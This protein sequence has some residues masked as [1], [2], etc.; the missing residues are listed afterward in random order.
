MYETTVAMKFNQY[1]W[2]LYKISQ[3]GKEMID[4]LRMRMVTLYSASFYQALSSY[5]KT[6][7]KI[8]WK[9]YIAT[10]YLST[11]YQ[12]LCPKL[13]ILFAP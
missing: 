11:M 4:F 10:A 5:R 12:H 6:Y 7:T 2:E 1:T 9:I 3:K 13:K 8:G